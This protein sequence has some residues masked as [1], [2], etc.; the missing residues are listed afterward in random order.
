[1]KDTKYMCMNVKQE[2][3]NRLNDLNLG[4]YLQDIFKIWKDSESDQP[5]P[6]QYEHWTECFD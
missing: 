2:T 6:E 4:K 3:N 1:M 5:F